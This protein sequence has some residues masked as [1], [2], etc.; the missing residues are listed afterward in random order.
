MFRAYLEATHAEPPITLE[1]FQK[2]CVDRDLLRAA[3]LRQLRDFPILLS[4]ISTEPAFLHSAGNYLPGQPHNYRDTM[5]FCQ[6]LNLLGLPGLS[7][8]M[9]RSPEGLPIN[10][11]LIARPH[12]EELL[13]AVAAQLENSRGPWQPPPQ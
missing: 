7:L 4:A 10:I 8:P 1:S 2:A 11:Q 6:W 13:L 3:I 12:E 9:G 5:R